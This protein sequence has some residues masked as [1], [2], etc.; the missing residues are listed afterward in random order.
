MP[1]LDALKNSGTESLTARELAGDLLISA[2]SHIMEPSD[3]WRERLP[4]HLRD[5]APYSE[6]GNQHRAASDTAGFSNE[7]RGAFRPGGWDSSKRVEEMAMDGVSAEVLFPTV[8][9]G[10]FAMEDAELQE[11]CF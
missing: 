8:T 2:D 9:L 4:A 6:R 5:R 1:I 11:A 10:Q 7:T 3:L